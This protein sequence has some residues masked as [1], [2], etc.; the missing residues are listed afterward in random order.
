[1]T[2]ALV[3][4]AYNKL[5]LERCPG[6][7]DKPPE[8]ETFGNVWNTKFEKIKIKHALHEVRVLRVFSGGDE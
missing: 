2:C 7:N 3:Q 6:G 8:Y 4:F 5:C 1:M